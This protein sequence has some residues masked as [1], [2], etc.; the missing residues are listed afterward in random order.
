[1]EGLQA[2]TGTLTTRR[3]ELRQWRASD[4]EPFA[5]LNAD[6]EV[7]EF[8]GGCLTRAASDSFAAWAESELSQRGWGVWAVEL[9]ATRE[10]IGCV[11]LSVPSFEADFTPCTEILWRL[12]RPSWGHGYATEAAR[13]CLRFA[14]A[15][16]VLPEVVSFTATGNARSRAVMERLGMRY[17]GEF[18]HP[19]L[20][21]GHPLRPHVLYRL[22]RELW[23]RDARRA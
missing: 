13:E 3:L 20:P 1:V 2:S 8:M 23:Q 21:A 16:L 12:T 14:F 17:A 19:R 11:G 18:E 15:T 7:M 6:P 10:F 22:T 9:S 4:L 5:A